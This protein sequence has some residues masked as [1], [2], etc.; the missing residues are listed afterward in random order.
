MKELQSK[1]YYEEQA[2]ISALN[3][4]KTGLWS[5]GWT[6][7]KVI[8]KIS[9]NTTKWRTNTYFKKSNPAKD[10]S[11]TLLWKFRLG[12]GEKKDSGSIKNTKWQHFPLE[13]STI[14]RS[15]E[16]ICHYVH[17]WKYYASG[18]RLCKL[19]D[20]A[21]NDSHWS[22]F[23]FFTLICSNAS[24]DQARASQFAW[25]L[26]LNA[27]GSLRLNSETQNTCKRLLV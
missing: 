26:Q 25:W 24:V 10:I 14:I 11:K 3:I 9:S 13:S 15:P 20:F 22:F 12:D 7:T 6:D 18:G 21:W 19:K 5:S 4:E 23:L 2:T 27:T 8:K 17:T 1:Y 16:E